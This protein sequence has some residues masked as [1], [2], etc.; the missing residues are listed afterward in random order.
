MASSRSPPCPLTHLQLSLLLQAGLPLR[1]RR[2]GALQVLLLRLDAVPLRLVLLHPLLRQLQHPARL[3]ALQHRVLSLPRHAARLPDLLLQAGQR[4]AA[5]V[6][7][8]GLGLCRRD[9]PPG[10]LYRRLHLRQGRHRRLRRR[11][12]LAPQTLSLS[13]GR[14]ERGFGGGP[15]V[16]SVQGLCLCVSDGAR[17][18]LLLLL[19]LRQT[20]LQRPI[21]SLQLAHRLHR[22]GCMVR[23]GGHPVN[24]Q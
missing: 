11:H 4:L 19:Q 1:Q 5:A 17:L 7:R 3:L 22:D 2:Q 24:E 8:P 10:A 21:L 23:G 16:C 15:L 6:L 12:N 20:Q 13:L 9:P 14:L 18:V